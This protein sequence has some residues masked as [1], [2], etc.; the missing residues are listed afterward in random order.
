MAE[1]KFTWVSDPEPAVWDRL[2]EHSPQGNLFC[3]RSYLDLAGVRHRRYLIM[4]GNH[5]KAGVCTIQTEDGK[6]CHL[7]DLV[8]HNGLLFLPDHQ[9]KA[10]KLRFEQFEITEFVINRMAEQ[11]DTIELALAPQFEDMRPFLWHEYHN[12]DS[13]RRF[14]LDLRYTTY[15]NIASLRSDKPEEQTPAFQ[16]MELL[17]QRHIRE[18]GKRGGLV[19]H[20]KSGALL[21]DYYRQLMKRQGDTPSEDKLNRMEN[22]VNG[23]LAAGRGGVY[24][25]RNAADLVIYV[26]A[27][28][29]DTKRAYYLF[30]AGHP[31]ISEP[32]QGTLAHWNAFINLAR[33]YNISEVD[34]EGVNS[35]KRGWFKLGFGGNLKPYYQIYRKVESAIG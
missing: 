3:E 15:I 34:M 22:L 5:V 27:Y 26:V 32:W 24:E 2:I 35:P 14:K 25:V 19:S 4:Q 31:E 9:K 18:A 10:V 30:G 33:Q 12:P 20:G 11:F 16:S 6:N 17:R 13:R 28:G 21:V 29:W 23:L 1:S 7:D 8:I